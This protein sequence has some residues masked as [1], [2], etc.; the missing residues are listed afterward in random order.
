[1]NG[2]SIG[3]I[4]EDVPQ[5]PR[6]PLATFRHDERY[7]TAGL[8][9]AIQAYDRT[10]QTHWQETGRSDGLPWS[11]NTAGAYRKVYF[12]KVYPVA[13]QQGFLNDK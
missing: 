1:V 4:A 13:V 9:E 6:L 2:V 8:R 10:L 12:P 3:H 7:V 5:K 11:T